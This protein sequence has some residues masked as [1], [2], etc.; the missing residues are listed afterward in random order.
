MIQR[1]APLSFFLSTQQHGLDNRH[2]RN[3]VT[4]QAA[5]VL[6]IGML[7][8][9][10]FLVLCGSAQAQPAALAGAPGHPTPQRAEAPILLYHHVASGNSQW[11]VSPDHF[12]A[13][14]RYLR[15]NDY[16]AIT[17]S[18]Y[19]EGADARTLPAKTVVLTFDDGYDDMYTNAFPL[20]QRYQMKGTFY[21]ITGRVGERGYLTWN[22]IREMQ[23]AGMEIG[24]HT[25]TH[26]FLTKL[27]PAAVFAQILLSKIAITAML[28]V[29]PVTFAYPYNDRNPAVERVPALLGFRAALAVSP[30]GKDQPGNRFT[31]P[32]ITIARGDG[33]H[34][35]ALVLNR[36]Y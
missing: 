9:A 13:Q 33:M 29:P 4:R 23:A 27:H 36:G 18:G 22:Q 3:A 34:T 7:N 12:E 14:L 24:A 20:L 35:F 25:F 32:R 8:G 21:I 19:L 17:V 16:Q 2:R 31:I 15:Q 11:F 28:G 10:L 1:R 6:L 30:H 5:L 26:P